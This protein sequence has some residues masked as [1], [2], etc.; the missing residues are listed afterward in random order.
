MSGSKPFQL[1]PIGDEYEFE[2]KQELTARP[3]DKV[4]YRTDHPVFD[5]VDVMDFGSEFFYDTE[6]ELNFG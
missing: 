6:Q 1:N 2:R 4:R 3:N 5:T